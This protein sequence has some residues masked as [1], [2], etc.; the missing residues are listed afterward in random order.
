MARAVASF[1]TKRT[2]PFVYFSLNFALFPNVFL[3][4]SEKMPIFEPIILKYME[5]ITINT[6]TYNYAKK[7]AKIQNLSV[8]EWIVKLINSFAQE[9]S[10]K[11]RFKMLP[12]EELS[13]E[14][15][16]IMRMPIVG[17]IDAD[18]INAEKERM[19]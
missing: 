13:P 5:T 16:E 14:L 3:Q 1:Y 10:K 6:A 11:K 7:Y 18:D 15:Q 12:I 9:S 8:D 17:S 19:S 4:L 2:V